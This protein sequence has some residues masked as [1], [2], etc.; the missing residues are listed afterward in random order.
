MLPD[1]ADDLRNKTK[2]DRRNLLQYAERTPGGLYRRLE[3]YYIAP[4]RRMSCSALQ[5]AAEEGYDDFVRML[6]DAGADWAGTPDSSHEGSAPSRNPDQTMYGDLVVNERREVINMDGKVVANLSEGEVSEV[7]GKK[8]NDKSE[9]LDLNGNVIGKV[10]LVPQDHH[11][12]ALM[13]A[14]IGQHM[15]TVTLLLEAAIYEGH[16][17]RI[18]EHLQLRDAE[19]KTAKDYAAGNTTLEKQLE[20]LESAVST[21]APKDAIRELSDILILRGKHPLVKDPGR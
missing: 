15:E 5:I 13:R 17:K 20:R 4:H 3:A 8:L 18:L 11:H 19:G 9:V 7:C 10:S 16:H 14:V 12:T 21:D 2:G 1:T 6:L